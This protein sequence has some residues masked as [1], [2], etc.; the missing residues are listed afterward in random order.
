[1]RI[2]AHQ[3][4]WQLDRSDY[5]WMQTPHAAI[6][7]DFLPADLAPLL[8]AAGVDGTVL[9][10]ADA[11]ARET[12]FMLEIAAGTPNVLGVV[13]WIDFTAADAV[14]QVEYRAGQ[15]KLRGL[16]PMLEFIPDPEWILRSDFKPVLRAM[17]QHGLTFD[18]LVHPQHLPALETLVRRHPD[19]PVVIDHGAKPKLKAWRGN[20]AAFNAWRD[21]MRKL[22]QHGRVYCKLSGL[23]TEAGV[24][25]QDQNLL[26]AMDA[27]LDLFGPSRL[28]WGSDWP[29]MTLAGDY[30]DW[31]RLSDRALT[32]LT[33][34]ERQQVCAANAISFYKLEVPI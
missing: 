28:I 11:T 3:H 15:G 16:R 24:G 4:Y 33:Q 10:Q 31:A 9:V 21:D 27:L 29:V 6:R 13:G 2:D 23:L 18:A 5:A 17:V 34:A 26:P 8:K 1:M 32:G 20:A 25:W 12:D 7:R 22:A 19:L 30:S 14:A